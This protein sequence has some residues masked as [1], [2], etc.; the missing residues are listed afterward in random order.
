MGVLVAV[1]GGGT[2]VGVPPVAAGR[3]TKTANSGPVVAGTGHPT[4]AATERPVM[5]RVTEPP[6]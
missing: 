1:G 5:G 6:A 4:G 3:T 2:G